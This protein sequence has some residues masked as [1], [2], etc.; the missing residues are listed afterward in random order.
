M[1]NVFNMALMMCVANWCM[2][3]KSIAASTQLVHLLTIITLWLLVNTFVVSKR[4]GTINILMVLLAGRVLMAIK[5][6]SLLLFY[7]FFEL[8]IVPITLI[9][10]LFGY[11]PEK[12]QA[13]LFLLLYTVVG[14][15]P[16]LL[17]IVV[18]DIKWIM[19][20]VLS[21]PVTLGFMV[22]TPLYLLHIWLPKAHVEAPVGGS[23]I[24]AGVLLKLG[25]YGLVLFLPL[26]HFNICLSFYLSMALVGS[27]VTSLIC[28]RQGDLKLLIAYSSVVHMGVVTIGFMRGTE[29]G[30]SCAIMMVVAHGLCSPFLFSFAHWIYETSHSRLILNNSNSW[31]VR[32]GV[33]MILISANMGLPPGLG[34]WSEVMI[35]IRLVVKALWFLPLLVIILFLGTA[36]NL[37][38]YTSLIHAKF[39]PSNKARTDFF[40]PLFQSTFCWYSSFFCLDLF[41]PSYGSM[42]YEPHQYILTNKNNHTTSTKC[43]YQALASK[44]KWCP[45]LKCPFHDRAHIVARNKVPISTCNPWKPVAM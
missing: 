22:K 43:Q 6:K 2:R 3:N 42:F 8:R 32:K 14:S 26:I 35:A 44:P 33:F 34:L 27:I 5:T 24:L 7:V 28:L 37:Y 41:H 13:S 4:G 1:L 21:L 30:Y 17:F 16:L 9:L 20:R 29:T 11:Q 36:Y 39:S 19:A 12:L 15:I 40:L 18:G 25:S 31:P 23:M 10:F 38:F 45:F